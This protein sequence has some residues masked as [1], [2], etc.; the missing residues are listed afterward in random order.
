MTMSNYPLGKIPPGAGAEAIARARVQ[1]AKRITRLCQNL[2]RE[3]LDLLLDRMAGIQV[4]YELLGDFP[5]PDSERIF[6]DDAET[7]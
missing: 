4:K 1:I 6:R 2:T 5:L 3:E 7:G